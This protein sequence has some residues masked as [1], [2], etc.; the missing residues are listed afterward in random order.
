MRR[1]LLFK[2][3][4]M[5]K[6]LERQLHHL[7]ITGLIDN[8]RCPTTEELRHVSGVSAVQVREALH[9]LE[10]SHCV[11]LHPYSDRVWVVH[12]FSVTPTHT[13]VQKGK[14]GWWAPCIWC[15]LGVA[16]LV[17]GDVIIH[18]RIGGKEEPVAISVVDGVPQTNAL[19]AHFAVPPVAAW[20]NVHHHCA[21][22]LPFKSETDI[23]AWSTM[24]GLERGKAVPI[25]QAATLARKW[26]DGHAG[27]NFQKWT[28]PQ[29][30]QIFHDAGLQEA[31]WSIKSG[32]KNF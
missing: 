6:D 24:H 12:P 22:L 18:A 20:N 23:D 9:V 8:C 21:M 1:F 26:Y 15:A 2:G 7:I 25:Q 11:V 16:E 10:E 28:I 32:A 13:Y 14:K 31:F 19:Y 3:K 30:Q 29:A 17:K 5:L 4:T 27:R